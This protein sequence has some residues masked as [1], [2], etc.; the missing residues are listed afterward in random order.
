MRNS[1]VLYLSTLLSFSYSS[2]SKQQDVQFN[3]SIDR[4][5]NIQIG[6]SE[7]QIKTVLSAPQSYNS[8]KFSSREY[9]VLEYSTPERDPAAFFI[10]DPK[11]NRIAGRSIWISP[12][13]TESNLDR[14]L[15]KHFASHR[16][17]KYIPCQ[18]SGPEEVLID[19]DHG[20]SIVTQNKQ[21]Q[22]LSWSDP[23]LTRLRVA[24]FYEKCPQL[25]E[26]H[27]SK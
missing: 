12:Q 21:V 6:D 4:F 20:V 10:V 8:E 27:T 26:A 9:R 23:D 15:R 16:F 17:Q 14:T 13:D 24:R 1:L 11:T 25:Q 5:M 22:M 18:S 19:Q 7:G 3:P 2:P